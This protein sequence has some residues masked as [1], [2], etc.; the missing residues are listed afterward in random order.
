MGAGY[1]AKLRRESHI[2]YLYRS[3][4][5]IRPPSRISKLVLRYFYPAHKPPPPPEEDSSRSRNICPHQRWTRQ[6]L[7]VL[8]RPS[9]L[10]LVSLP[11]ASGASLRLALGPQLPPPPFTGRGGGRNRE[12]NRRIP[13]TS[14]PLRFVLRLR[15]QRGGGGGGAFAGHYGIH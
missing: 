5:Q 13:R 7:R 3:V 11:V 2:K 4:P 10:K 9:T 15:L 6:L 8:P 12:R 1:Q 14:P